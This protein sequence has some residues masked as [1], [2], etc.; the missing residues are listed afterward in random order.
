MKYIDIQTVGP[1]SFIVWAC[2]DGTKTAVVLNKDGKPTIN[3]KALGMRVTNKYRAPT[4]EPA[5]FN[6]PDAI[7]FAHQIGR[8]VFKLGDLVW[9]YTH[10]DGLRNDKFFA[11]NLAEALAR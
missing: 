3:Q 7:N 10:V 1:D 8:Y 9:G 2:R 11:D 6:R 5:V 4:G